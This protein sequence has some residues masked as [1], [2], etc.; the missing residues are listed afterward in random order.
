M[1]ADLYLRIQ[2]M[3]KATS[4]KQNLPQPCRVSRCTGR[5]HQSNGTPVSGHQMP[6]QKATIVARR[7]DADQCLASRKHSRPSGYALLFIKWLSRLWIR[8]AGRR[9]SHGSRDAPGAKT[10]PRIGVCP[11]VEIRRS[12]C[13]LASGWPVR[14]ATSSFIGHDHQLEN[15][16]RIPA[17]RGLSAVG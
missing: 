17:P 6:R 9:V 10:A 15:P 8:W 3:G 16:N 1:P 7:G 2:T 14:P 5:Q 12:A 4:G 11:G 13:N